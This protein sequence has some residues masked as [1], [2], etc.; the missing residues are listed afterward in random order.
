MSDRQQLSEHGTNFCLAALGVIA[1]GGSLAIAP[2]PIAVLTMIGFERWE[3]CDRATVRRSR[4]AAE[5]AL[6]AFP[7]VLDSDISTGLQLLKSAPQKVT[8]VPERMSSAV[9]AGNIEDALLRDIVGSTLTDIEPG[10]RRVIEVT[11]KAAFDIFR[12]NQKYRDVFTQAMVMDLLSEKNV[13]FTLLEGIKADTSLIRQDTTQLK[14]MVSALQAQL[15]KDVA[16]L[17]PFAQTLLKNEV[18]IVALSYRYAEGGNPENFEAA[19]LGLARALEV[20]ANSSSTLPSNTSDAVDAVLAEVDRLNNLGKL[21][22]AAAAIEAEIRASEDREAQ[23]KSARLRLFNKGITQSILTRSVE[24]AVKFEYAKVQLDH[25]APTAHFDALRAIQIEWYQ[26]GRDKGLDFDLSVSITLAHHCLALGQN[27]D[28]R[29]EALIDL[30]VSFGTLGERETGTDRLEQAIAAYT[31]ALKEFTHDRAPL[32]WAVTQNN[33]GNAL[34]T[35]GE[36]EAGTDR[37]EQAVTA[38]T[39]AL[40]ERTRDRDPL[41]WALTQSNLGTAL[42]SLGE[43]EAGTD[44]LER[45]VAAYTDALKE[46]T[47]DRVPLDWAMTQNNLGTALQTLGAREAGTE[48]LM[49][50]VAAYT[51]ALKEYTRDS[52]PLNW[53]MTQNNLGNALQTLGEREAGT[54]RLE[55][56][57]AAFADA[58]KEY[59]RDRAPLDW[60]M[61]Q[62]NLGAA[63]QTLGAREAGTDRLKQAIAAYTEALKERTRDRDPLG[64]AATMFNIA[65]THL[66]LTAKNNFPDPRPALR[67]ALSAVDAALEVYDAEASQFYFEQASRLRALILERLNNL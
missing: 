43:R 46:R 21:D 55:R 11:L 13:E 67:D 26:R 40:K 66:A 18:F 39:E 57:I 48:R 32:D 33:L 51:D 54:G 50:A 37:L 41:D 63:L 60:A 16:N 38:Y 56:A 6:R 45:A 29:G 28:Q 42:Q 19:L 35:L 61:T 17:S 62:N 2:L 1:G 22:E 58:L 15:S 64:W 53:A 5:A 31:E 65:L 23:E 34:Q 47:R 9:R 24:H 25:P 44:R 12:Q 49:Q 8:F 14:A 27:A 36:R 59:T 7:D 30:G 20:A 3:S 52:D 4:K 10:P